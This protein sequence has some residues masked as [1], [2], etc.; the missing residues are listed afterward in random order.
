MQTNSKKKLDKL[1]TKTRKLQKKLE[2][3]DRA[4]VRNRKKQESHMTQ[5]QS[6]TKAVNAERKCRKS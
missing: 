1:E 2:K 6:I 4:Q 3:K 5:W